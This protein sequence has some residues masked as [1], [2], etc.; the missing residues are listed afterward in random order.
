LNLVKSPPIVQ[1]K[2]SVM[3][4]VRWY[5]KKDIRVENVPDPKIINPR[6]AI[7]EVTSTAICG[8]DLH[9]Y[10]GYVLGMKKG[11]I[12]GHEFAG[13]VVEVGKG[14]TNLKV[15]DRVTVPFTIQCGNCFH[16]ARQEYSL[17]DN[18][19]PNGHLLAKE[20]GY[21]SAGLFGYTH[22]YGGYPG[23]QAQYVRVPFADIGPFKLPDSVTDEQGALLADVFPTGYMAAENCGITPGDTIAVWGCGPVGQFAIRSA[24]MLGA[25]R[26]IAIDRFPERLELAARVQGAE[27]VNYEEVDVI[28]ALKFM[29]GGR[30]P[31]ACI[32]AVGMEAH[33]HS[34]DAWVDEAL[35]KT[36]LETDRSHALRQAIKACRKG[37]TI[38]MPGVYVGILDNFPLGAAFAKGLTFKMGQTHVPKYL[39]RLVEA[40]ERGEVDPTAIVSHRLKMDDAA[41]GYDIWSKKKEHVTKILL[42][43]RSSGSPSGRNGH[44]HDHSRN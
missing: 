10:H 9:F 34:I 15:G 16:C 19:N 27:I 3:R 43:P 32:D 6:D 1:I 39:P 28:E 38:S 36:M 42:D 29:T 8:S 33:G 13:K 21:G 31:D 44:N 35:Q 4:A 5:G 40:I 18:S 26:V 14:V 2:E 24:F 17:C 25:D 22:L 11:D 41:H 12:V 37:G 30:G 20:T 7:V 23:G